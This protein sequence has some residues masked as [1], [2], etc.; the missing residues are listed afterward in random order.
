MTSMAK[1]AIYAAE[2]ERLYV[3]QGLSI[4]AILGILEGKISRKTLYN[5]KIEGR[6]DEKREKHQEF[7]IE[8]ADGLRNLVRKT[9]T[10]A[11]ANPSR[12]SILA[13]K[14]AFSVAKMADEPLLK[15]IQ[16]TTEESQP[17][18]TDEET[19]KAA[20][21]ALFKEAYGVDINI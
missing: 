6:W 1:Q 18:A 12:T 11:L 7:E 21:R 19:K 16:G 20:L 4:D 10:E 5:W 15:F 17:S 14:Q 2:A 3:N 8:I 9:L 13:F